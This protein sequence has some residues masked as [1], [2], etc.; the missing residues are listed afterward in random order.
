MNMYVSWEEKK[1]QITLVDHEVTDLIY[2]TGHVCSG[3]VPAQHPETLKS[4]S[5]TKL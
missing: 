4:F 1:R 2:E 5:C 3:I